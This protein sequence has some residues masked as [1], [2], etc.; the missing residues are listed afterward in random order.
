MP[1]PRTCG[2]ATTLWGLASPQGG[3]MSLDLREAPRESATSSFIRQP[4]AP[5]WR[6]WLLRL[7]LI[8]VSLFLWFWTQSML[9]SRPVPVKI[10]DALHDWTASLNSYFLSQPRSAN[11]LLIASSIAIDMLGIFMLAS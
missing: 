7:G 6:L 2:H 9:G 5:P 11:A 4:M 1:W 8:A 10:G 3:Y